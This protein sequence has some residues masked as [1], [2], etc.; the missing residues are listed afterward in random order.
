MATYISISA[1]G[2]NLNSKV[3]L[4]AMAYGT[5]AITPRN[6]HQVLSQMQ[7]ESAGNMGQLIG[8]R[9]HKPFTITREVDSSSPLLWQAL[10]T[11]ETLQTVVIEIIGRPPTG[12]GETV[13]ERITLTNATISKVARYIPFPRPR[14]GNTSEHVHTNELEQIELTFQKIT[15]ANI[16]KST[17][18]SDDWTG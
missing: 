16:S 11:N 13:V 4:H 12:A 10:S 17:S 1:R 18:T 7:G 9:Q 3:G 14:Q 5:M 15:F 6:L 8:K 2:R